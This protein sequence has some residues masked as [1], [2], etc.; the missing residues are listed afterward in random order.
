MCVIIPKILILKMCKRRVIASDTVQLSNLVFLIFGE[1]MFD[2]VLFV[3]ELDSHGAELSEKVAIR[4]P[5]LQGGEE[6]QLRR[7]TKRRRGLDI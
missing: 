3:S 4:R 6:T 5:I 1:L 7:H 2:S